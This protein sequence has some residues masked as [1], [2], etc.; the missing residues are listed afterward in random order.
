MRLVVDNTLP[1]D[2]PDLYDGIASNEAADMPVG[3]SIA[4]AL[5]MAA[6]KITDIAFWIA[7]GVIV[8]LVVM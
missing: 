3:V 1:P 4:F 5:G 8:A 2:L 6:R 7:V